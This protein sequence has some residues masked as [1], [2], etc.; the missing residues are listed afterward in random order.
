MD[1]STFIGTKLPSVEFRSFSIRAAERG[2]S[3]SALMRTLALEFL[4]AQ[5]AARKPARRKPSTR[6]AA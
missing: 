6:R 4:S 3:K 2:L 1:N 5:N